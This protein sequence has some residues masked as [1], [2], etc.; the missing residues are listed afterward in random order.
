MT[1][2]NAMR[3]R[4][5]NRRCPSIPNASQGMI[6]MLHLTRKRRHATDSGFAL[7][8]AIL[9]LFVLAMLAGTSIAVS[10]R[11]SSSTTRDSN[12]KAALEAAEAGLQVA[13]YRLSKLQPGKEECIGAGAAKKS[14]GECASGEEHLGNG[15]SYQYWTT[16]P[17][18]LKGKCA[19]QEVVKVEAGATF[20]CVT[21]E[22]T[23]N[24]VKPGT[25]LRVLIESKAGESL[26]PSK[27]IV[28][29]KEVKI[30]GSVKVP[31]VV[32]SNEKIIGEGGAAFERGFELC[33]PNGAFT[34]KAGAE[35]NA[36]GVTVGGVGGTLANPP[37]EKT[38]SASECQ[39]KAP[40]PLTHATAASNED[41]RIGVQDEFYTEGKSA[42]KFT[43]APNYELKLSSK[44][45]LTLGGSKY[46]F[47]NVIAEHA[48]ELIIPAGAHVEIFIDSPED[49]AS[50]CPAGTGKF[51]GGEFTL[52]NH[53][54]P[55]ALLIVMYG[56][57]PFEITRGATFE[58]AI[59]A[60]E[61]EVDVNGGTK[62]KGG[63]V[64]NRVHLENGTGIFEWSEEVGTLTNGE[65]TGYAR[66]AWEQCAPGSGASEGC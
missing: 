59:Y 55:A 33:Q 1:A 10:S 62:F 47:C 21:S 58:G 2:S 15:A 8:S 34:P 35:R 53:A 44:S 22:G 37:L 60:P 20:R 13:S 66:K 43:G 63:I 28:G 51:E 14:E 64:G 30:S 12:T 29:L 49:K 32:A 5:P 31:A 7:P 17:L 46:Y 6:R 41:S 54:G 25:R 23:V 26:F 48:G 27:G 50:K 38:R 52:T 9:V 4:S 45:K 39:I 3:G 18:A 24:N 36:S 11:T 16:M 65:P 42:N 56:K 19:G 57:G 40:Y 61:A